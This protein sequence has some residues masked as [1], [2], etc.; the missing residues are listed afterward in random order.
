M[1]K[2]SF[3]LRRAVVGDSDSLSWLIVHFQPFVEAQA[4]MRLGPGIDE[5][6]VQDLVA[7]TWVI[8][9]RSIKELKARDGH[10]APVLVRYLSTTTI[11]LCNTFL[12]KMIRERRSGLQSSESK[13]AGAVDGFAERT[14]GIINQVANNEVQRIVNDCLEQLPKDKRE[15]LLLRFMEQRSNAEIAEILELRPNTV[16]VRY[17]R[18]LQALRAQLP[19]SLF[20]DIWAASGRA[21]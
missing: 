3:H 7:D 18:A 15:V 4:R 20:K 10:L 19:R 17:R 6:D 13:L 11:Q 14:H 9:L 5:H 12:R 8:T 2:T 21:G 1:D 16:A